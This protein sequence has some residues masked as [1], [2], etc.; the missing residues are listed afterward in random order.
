MTTTNPLKGQFV[1]RMLKR[2]MANQCTKREASS[3]SH[4]RHILG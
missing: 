3:F 1:K 4:S 2:H